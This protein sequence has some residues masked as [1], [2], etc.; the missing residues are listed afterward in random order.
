MSTQSLNPHWILVNISIDNESA[1]LGIAKDRFETSL[2]QRPS[3]SVQAVVP[4]AEG[5]HI[6]PYPSN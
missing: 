1:L 5:L 4:A 2:K 3:P 6:W